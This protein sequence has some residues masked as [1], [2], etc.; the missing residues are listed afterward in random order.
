MPL[1]PPPLRSL[2]RLDIASARASKGSFKE[3]AS[4]PAELKSIVD[5]IV[6]R[7]VNWAV[8]IVYTYIPEDVENM[9]IVRSQQ[10][11]YSGVEHGS[12]TYLR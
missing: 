1:P 5:E 9:T 8:I 2:M 7:F 12:L 4:E 10:L 6:V 11:V 3:T